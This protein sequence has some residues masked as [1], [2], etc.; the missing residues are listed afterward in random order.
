MRDEYDIKNL[1]PQKNPYTKNT[2]NSKK[3]TTI[4][5]NEDFIIYSKKRLLR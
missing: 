2:K 5:F 4:K 1:N 3:T